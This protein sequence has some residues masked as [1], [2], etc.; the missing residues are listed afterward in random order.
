MWYF[1]MRYIYKIHLYKY[2]H[3]LELASYGNNIIYIQKVVCFGRSL[4]RLGRH[5]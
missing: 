1:I 2:H 4:Y 3:L 5:I